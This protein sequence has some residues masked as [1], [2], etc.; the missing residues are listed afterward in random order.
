[1]CPPL[2]PRFS[3]S[4]CS[5]QAYLLFCEPIITLET[6]LTMALAGCSGSCSANRW[7]TLSVEVPVFLATKPK[8]LERRSRALNRDVVCSLNN[9]PSLSAEIS[10]CAK[11]VHTSLTLLKD[12]RL[13]ST[14]EHEKTGKKGFFYFNFH[15]RIHDHCWC[16]GTLTFYPEGLMHNIWQ[17]WRGNA[18][19]RTA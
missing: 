4:R 8:I 13:F 3:P 12:S 9:A 16:S 11:T 17:C 14:W 6:K 1:M 19:W 10:I 18:S 2:P 15:L 7:H 5:A